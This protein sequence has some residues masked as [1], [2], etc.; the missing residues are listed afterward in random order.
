LIKATSLKVGCVTTIT[1]E[2]EQNCPEQEIPEGSSK[3]IAG[4]QGCWWRNRCAA[5]PNW[6]CGLL[7]FAMVTFV[8]RGY[9][10]IAALIAGGLADQIGLTQ[11][12]PWAIPLPSLVCGVL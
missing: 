5:Q 9:A 4:S 1:G 12:L 8:E 3:L 6:S 7:L 10:A 11:G 2:N